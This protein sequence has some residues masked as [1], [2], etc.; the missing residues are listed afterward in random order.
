MRKSI[1]ARRG[2]SIAAA[3]LSFALVAP[4]AQ[5]VAFAQDNP[6]ASAAPASSADKGAQQAAANDADP[7][8]AIYSPGISGG[9]HTISGNAMVF[10]QLPGSSW[11]PS[12]PEYG[13]ALPA[14]NSGTGANFKGAT[15][16]A[17]WF[18]KP[19]KSATGGEPNV[20]SPIY[21]TTVNEDGTFAINMRPYLDPTGQYR[22]FWAQYAFTAGMRG[23]RVKIWV[24]GYDRNEFR[25]ARGYGERVMPDGTVI[26]T[27][28]G[29]Y[30]NTP[31]GYV[32]SAHQLFVRKSKPEEMLGPES[33]WREVSEQEKKM[34]WS[35]G[36]AITGKAYWNL[37]QGLGKQ[38]QK[39]L[40]GSSGDRKVKGL[41]VVG[42]YLSDKAVNAIT[43]YAEENRGSEFQDHTLRGAGWDIQDETKL[44]AWI[45]DQIKQNPDWIAEKVT[46]TTDGNGEYR[47]QFKGTYGI[48]PNKP[49]YVPEELAGTVAKD[50]AD[51]TFTANTAYLYADAKHVNWDWMYVEAP[52]LPEGTSNMG[53]W[54]G[55]V[56]QGLT[57]TNWGVSNLATSEPADQFDMRG[58]QAVLRTPNY[59]ISS[60]DM[61]LFPNRINFEVAKYDSK[62]KFAR[63]GDSTFAQTASLPAAD[64]N[65][66]YEVEWTDSNG[67]VLQVCK[68]A[69]S[70]GK[71]LPSGEG[72]GL[73]AS[74]AGTL[75]NCPVSVPEDLKEKTI[76]T[77]TL[78][79]LD[80]NGA[81]IPLG[82]DSFTAVVGIAAE[83]GPEYKETPARIGEETSS[84]PATFVDLE[85]GEAIPADDKR[86]EG[87]TFEVVEDAIPEGWVVA[88]DPK[89]GAVTFTAGPNGRDGHALK[90]GDIEEIPVRVKYSDG[91]TNGAIAP[92]R[93][94][95]ERD[96]V[97]PA[98]DE[99]RVVP[100]TPASTE[101]KFFAQQ[102]DGTVTETAVEHP[103]G[104]SFK[105]D[106]DFETPAGY[107]VDVDPATGKVTVTAP[108]KP[109]DDTAEVVT[110]PVVVTYKD[111]TEDTVEA[112]FKLDTDGD[113]TPDVDDTDDD[114]DGIDD[115]DEEKA[116]TKSKDAN[117]APSSIGDIDDATV[118]VRE[119]IA[120][121]AV[122][123]E[124]LP[125]GGS[126]E[127][128]GL[129]DGLKY[130]KETGQIEGTPTTPTPEGE[131]AEVTVKVLGNDGKPVVDKDGKPVEK[132]FK[133]TVQSQAGKYNPHGK[134]QE[135]AKNSEPKAEDSVA[136]KDELPEGTEYA[137][138]EAPKTDTSGDK[139]A[140][141]VVT[142]PDG[143]TDEVPVTVKVAK[144]QAEQYD[145]EGKD[146]TVETG[147]KPEP[148]D[149]VKDADKLP[150]DTTFK[151]KDD[152][153]TSTAGDKPVTVI[154]TYPDGSTDE[155]EAK[156]VVQDKVTQA[157]Q[158]DPQGK[159][160]TVETGKKPEPKNNVEDA[161]SLPKGTTF[162]YKEDP[163]TSTAGD[164]PV[165]VIVTYPDGSTDEVQAT[166]KVEEPKTED[167]KPQP[168]KSDADTYEPQVQDKTVAPNEVPEAKD[169]VTNI[170]ELPEGTTFEYEQAP[171]TSTE[172]DKPVT[173]VVTYPDGT[174][175]KVNANVKVQKNATDADKHDPQG[176]DQKV[177]KGGTPDA[178]GNIKDADS[179]PKGTSFKYKETPDT[180]KPGVYDVTVVVTYP[181][182]STD[183]VQ[184]TITV[185]TDAE[186]FV[187]EYDKVTG[188][189]VDGEEN[190]NDP[191]GTKAPVESVEAKKPEGA[192]KWAFTPQE[193][194]V[195]KAKAPSMKDVS[196]E[197]KAKLPELKS[198]DVE[199]RWDKFFETF[200]P[201]ARPAVEVDFTYEDDSTNSATANFDLIG[202]DGKSLL[203]PNG[204]FDGD[205]V[206]NEAE[207]KAGSDPANDGEKPDTTAPTVNPITAGDTKISGKGD[208]PNETI[209]VTLPNGKEL[210]ATTDANG[211]W[212]VNLPKGVELKQ[213]DKINVRDGHGNKAKT[214]TVAGKVN[215]G[216]CAASAVGFGLP[217]IALLP[218][219]LA[220]QIQIPVLSDLAGQVEAQLKTA[221]TRIQQQAGIFNPE[222]AAQAER[223]NAQLRTVGAD[224]GMVVAGIALIAAGVL[225]GTFIYDACKPGG[226]SSSVKDLEL[227]GSSGKTTK[228]SSEHAKKDDK[229]TK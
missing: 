99:Q 114:G 166:V 210:E 203:D 77:A 113:G 29:V 106:P 227:K 55:N 39:D 209:I 90:P 4:L 13:K 71:L 190:T 148:K 44:Q 22:E 117:S 199:K 176:Q 183:E 158:H 192:E 81:R 163:D 229:L 10:D 150:K 31:T 12:L 184:T 191:F 53:A 104:V 63:K 59:N 142:Y 115:V 215:A 139:P 9:K 6:P 128:T 198:T 208:R 105:K 16:Y 95:G 185:G 137:W 111:G 152:P 96:E 213:G 70:S 109:A 60:W 45:R 180:S 66:L 75:P 165:T 35:N 84:K 131:P 141:V 124:K 211:N 172:G 74:S 72:N 103:E 121:I 42:A 200:K 143:T 129:P 54:R 157:D 219:G 169:H 212:S 174:T 225:A 83:V 187:P 177:E 194:G 144:D 149:N 15:V 52:D 202:K 204:D 220:S 119:P 92:V 173:I 82:S 88:V 1:T 80:E 8:G 136:N 7:Y 73:T 68:G 20:A 76:Y 224:L 168:K 188:V 179:L 79:G 51:G 65:A 41:K 47:L 123:V 162:K 182:G 164:K 19:D 147:K 102:L 58:M 160:Q 140:V 201:F 135:V 100:G 186:R 130:N 214:V 50:A 85:S 154:V 205:G 116:G 89:T 167:P 78:Y 18:E 193:N 26:D 126:V 32:S 189:P 57:S 181:D 27:T 23:Q 62:T 155:V 127:V 197:F 38:A 61:V 97:E 11:G 216:A 217:L 122:V 228:L 108:E 28:G 101:P 2:T 48:L 110:V 112:V 151:Y 34:P 107:T 33:G 221:N 145:P 87:A 196:D 170:D 161:D 37:N 171:D 3:A 14:V 17:Q 21:K 223:I 206:T 175:D 125:T 218:L 118:T 159:D 24:D 132:T 120:P 40:A 91:T 134:D 5:P 43:K 69:D 56:W 153:D 178:K 64:M 49:G 156:V 195:L 67:K 94:A 36:G 30:W 146:Q 93:I 207:V 222:M 138:K 98:Y 133:I 25:A 86:L 46:T 226:P